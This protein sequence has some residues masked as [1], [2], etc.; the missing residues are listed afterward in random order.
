[1]TVSSRAGSVNSVLRGRLRTLEA[2]C[3]LVVA[4]VLIHGL[5]FPIATR[6]AGR[7]SDGDQD[8]LDRDPDDLEV[9]AVASAIRRGADRLPFG[10]TCLKRA[11]AGRLML[12]RRGK[13]SSLVIGVAMRDGRPAAHAWLMASGGVVCGGS[14]A[15]DF[16]PIAAWHRG[17]ERP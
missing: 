8:G 9:R 3:A 5:P 6:L 17:A 4:H 7:I 10:S 15:A 11:V 14:E 16:R 1:M 2:M 13:A 12:M